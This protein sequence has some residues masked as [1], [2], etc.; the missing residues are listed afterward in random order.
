MAFLAIALAMALADDAIA[1]PAETA[2][3][4]SEAPA[5]E[6][7]TKGDTAAKPANGTAKPADNGSIVVIAGPRPT[8]ED[9]MA[10]VNAEMFGAV[11]AVDG[12][13]IGPVALGYK[14]AVPE[15]VRSGFRNFLRNLDSP[16]VFLSFMLEGKPGKAFETVG[17]FAINSTIGV[18]GL[19]DVAK[20]RTFKLPFRPNGFA[21]VLGFYGVKPGPYFF[22]PLIGPT[23]LRD[24]IGGAG[25]AAVLPTAV[26]SP[27]NKMAYTLPTGTIDAIDYRAEFD[28]KLQRLRASGKHPYVA[29]RE[30][31]LW[32]R[33]AEIDE[34]K[35]RTPK[36]DPFGNVAVPQGSAAKP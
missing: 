3:K 1:P 19:A 22:L 33:Q 10:R 24:M 27:F 5:S 18:A 30:F 21:D 13:L 15:P 14:K 20:T 2:P 23:T 16:V 34:L 12:A 25:D 6:A 26:G 36:P 29:R 4:A 32:M 28:E 11:Q 35:G 8:K 9:P 7:T 31:Y 17:R